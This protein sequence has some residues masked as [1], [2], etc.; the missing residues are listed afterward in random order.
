MITLSWDVE[1]LIS[2]VAGVS[3]AAIVAAARAVWVRRRVPKALS[4]AVIRKRY[5]EEILAQSTK[6]T[7]TSLDVLS[8]RFAPR[9]DDSQITSLQ[10]AWAAIQARGRV[11]VI[12]GNADAAITGGAELVGRDIEVRISPSFSTENLSYHIF[13]GENIAAT[14]VN[15]QE[16]DKVQ[17]ALLDGVGPLDVFRHHFAAT[18]E[19]SAPVESVIAEQAILRA[20][21]GANASAVIQALRDRALL[22][23][24]D[25]GVRATV[26]KHAAFRHSSSI[27]FIV[28][29]PG[30]GKSFTRR[31]LAKQLRSL[32]IQTQEL[33][34]YVFAY[35]DFL[36]GSIKLAPPR[37]M[38]FEPDQAGAFMVSEENYLQP[39]LKSL[40]SRVMYGV[41]SQEVTLVEFARSDILAALQE[42]GEESILRS[43]IVYVEAPPHLREERLRRRARPPE[44][45]VSSAVTIT[46]TVSDDHRLPSAV[47]T[48][49]YGLDDIIALRS[50]PRWH[51]R[52]FTI[53]NDQDH[54]P[55]FEASLDE[56]IAR[57]ASPYMATR[58]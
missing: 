25:D 5:V 36:H 6:K 54:S 35:R 48:S 42:F 26:A 53:V 13:G 32:R 56:F 24:L 44:L 45:A 34:D 20:G 31:Q 21:L 52:V 19:A 33:T 12:I 18:W 28:G 49:I 7:V 8:P 3:V 29:L 47:Q 57:V 27:I 30:S 11:R 22:Y 41:T 55:Q 39:A 38:G 17:P 15:Q 16:D 10:D 58:H 43:Q 14:I 9:F 1:L 46:V 40:A 23:R 2:V 50:D 51:G 37:G 4:Q